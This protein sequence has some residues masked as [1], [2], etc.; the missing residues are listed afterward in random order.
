[1]TRKPGTLHSHG[2]LQIVVGD[3]LRVD[4]LTTVLA[5]HDAVISCLGQRSHQDANLLHDAAAAV[6][7]AMA[8]TGVRRYLVVSQGLLFPSWNPIFALLRLIL[9]RYI[10]DSAA[11]ERLVRASNVEW[12]IVRPPRLKEGGIPHGYRVQLG[13]RPGGAWAMQRADLAAFLL[14][15]AERGEHKNAIVGITSA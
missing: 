10:V 7:D 5:D 2:R 15:E 12:T 3:P 4:D 8:R 1:M 6:L 13:A 11:M 9:A 14:D